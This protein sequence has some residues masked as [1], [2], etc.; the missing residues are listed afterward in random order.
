MKKIWSFLKQHLREDFNVGHYLLTA[1]FL[2]LS[3]YLNYKFDYEDNILGS[4]LGFEKFLFYFVFYAVAY[5]FTSLSYLFFSKKLYILVEADFW[6]KSI[7]AVALLSFDS[8]APFLLDAIHSL[9]DTSIQFWA[10][11][12]AV[13]AM[14]F[15]VIVLPLIIF[16]R[17]YEKEAKNYYGLTAFRFDFSPYVIMLLIMIPVIAAASFD[18]SFLGQYP[19]YKSSGAHVYFGVDEWVTVSIYEFA[20]AMDFITVEY[21]FRGFMVI[22]LISTLGR[23]AVLS[24]AVAYCFLH[25]GKPPAEAISSIFGGYVLGVIAYE[26]KSIWGGI[27]I[28]MGIALSMELAAW[29]QKTIN[30]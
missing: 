22:A 7:L 10:Y 11:K 29:L 3:I 19:M 30:S 9:L 4:K 25:F 17:F 2:A 12:V 20:Y 21:L 23:G 24:M 16:Y 14:S 13:N 27:T 18:K 28:H 6:I 8:S 26:T 1:V 5:Y 15:F